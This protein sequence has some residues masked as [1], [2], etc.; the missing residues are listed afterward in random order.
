MDRS[1]GFWVYTRQPNALLRLISRPHSVNLATEYK[2]LTHYTKVRSHQTC[3]FPGT[4]CM[5]A[6][7]GSISPPHR[8]SF[9]LSSRCLVHYRSVREYL[10][11]SDGPPPYSDSSYAT[12]SFVCPEYGTINPTVGFALPMVLLRNTHTTSSATP[13][14]L[15]ATKGIQLISFPKG[16][17]MFHFPRLPWQH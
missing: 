12:S 2:S 1:P 16:T 14:L 10:A 3:R 4:A 13:C 8:G 7:S 5:H 15:A 6:V 9:C 11:W 17:E